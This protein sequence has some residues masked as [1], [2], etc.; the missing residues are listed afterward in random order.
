MGRKVPDPLLD[1]LREGA[2]DAGGR[3]QEVVVD[4]AEKID[5]V[6][7]EARYEG[8]HLTK[9]VKQELVRRWQSV[10]RVGRENA[11]L[12]AFSALAVGLAIGYLLTRD[13]D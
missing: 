3:V 9:K 13:R 1:S 7:D 4:M 5:D 2:A 8:I 6:L 11:F 12:M 10:D